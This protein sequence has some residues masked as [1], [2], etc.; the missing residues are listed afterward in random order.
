MVKKRKKQSRQTGYWILSKTG[1][2]YHKLPIPAKSRKA[3]EKQ[4]KMSGIKKFKIEYGTRPISKRY[5][6]RYIRLSDW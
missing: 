5:K 4:C 1:G 6:G 2:R 3:A